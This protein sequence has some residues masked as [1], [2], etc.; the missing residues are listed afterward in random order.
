MKS[1]A[2]GCVPEIAIM[3][4]GIQF[5][6]RIVVSLAG[7]QEVTGRPTNFG[8]KTV[9]KKISPPQ[10]KKINKRTIF[11]RHR[12]EFPWQGLKNPWRPSHWLPNLGCN[13]VRR[14]QRRRRRRLRTLRRRSCGCFPRMDAV[15]DV[16][17]GGGTLGRNRSPLNHPSR[18]EPPPHASRP[19]GVSFFDR[20]K[21]PGRAVVELVATGKGFVM[22]M[23]SP[24]HWMTS[25]NRPAKKGHRDETWSTCNIRYHFTKWSC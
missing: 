20:K 3:A 4:L 21:K 22:E 1:E 17:G 8:S 2:C 7:N 19:S 13:G 24:S 11:F 16:I 14:R 9:R 6:S 5:R 25:R 23:N 18:C 12:L 15:G 10:K